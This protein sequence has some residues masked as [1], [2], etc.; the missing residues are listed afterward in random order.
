MTK[1]KVGDLVV[2]IAGGEWLGLEEGDVAS[3]VEVK[4]TPN[5]WCQLRLD[6][7]DGLYSD[8]NFRAISEASYDPR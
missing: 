6:G 7:Y 5:N 8:F 1:F 4:P 3:V 2:R